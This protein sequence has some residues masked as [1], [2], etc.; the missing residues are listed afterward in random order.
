MGTSR[1]GIP[2]IVIYPT[3]AHKPK[4]QL[5]S[6]LKETG[7]TIRTFRSRDNDAAGNEVSLSPDGR[8]VMTVDERNGILW[9]TRTGKKLNEITDEQILRTTT[10]TPDSRYVLIGGENN[11]KIWDAASGRH[12][13][14]LLPRKSGGWSFV[15]MA[16]SADGKLVL[17]GGLV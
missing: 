16:V 12:V 14:D 10:F 13:R 11:I 17:A 8:M 15:S 9:D 3:I 7:K 6:F 4:F 5:N 2:H 1:Q